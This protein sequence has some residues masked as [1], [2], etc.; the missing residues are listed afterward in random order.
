MLAC[1]VL[2][3]SSTG[4]VGDP[5]VVFDPAALGYELR[6]TVE[7][8]QGLVNRTG[9]R[10][11]LG[12]PDDPWL[13]IYAERN[14]I[15][16]ETETDLAALFRRFGGEARG[17]VVYDP[18]VDGG[19]YVAATIAGAEGLLPV[20]P[21]FLSEASPIG[22]LGLPTVRDLR[23]QFADSVA[24]YD[25][26]IA[27]VFPECN[28]HLGLAVDATCEGI[29]TGLCGPLAG[30]DWSVQNR[31][32][33]FNLGVCPEPMPSYGDTKVGGSPEQAACYRRILA[34]LEAPAQINGYGEPEDYWCKLISEYG[35]YSFHYGYNWSFHS[36][37]PETRPLKQRVSY[38]PENVTPE[39]DR[40]A[41]CFMTSEGDTMKG[42]L[43]FFM[44]SWFDTER[45][46]VPVNWGINPLMADLFPAMLSYYYD[47]ATEQ[48]CFF[49]GCSGAGYAY[50]DYMPNLEQFASVTGEMCRKADIS[51]VDLWM[52]AKD[53]VRRRYAEASG[54]MGLSA[55]VGRARFTMP[56]PGVP[57]IDHGLMYWQT[58]ATA[59]ETWFKAFADDTKRAK[60]IDWLVGR[61]EDIARHHEAPFVI[62]VYGDLHSYAHHATC[63]REVADQLDPARFRPM[64]LDE[65]MAGLAAWSKGR[66]LVDAGGINER[67]QWAALEGVPT[68]VPLG[69]VSNASEPAD[70]RITARVGQ[71]QTRTAV[72]V[73]PGARTSADGLMLLLA[74]GPTTREADLTIEGPWGE[75]VRHPTVTLVPANGV[76]AR[77]ASLVGVWDAVSLNHSGGMERPEPDALYGR[78]WASPDGEGSP[79]SHII[80][81]PY[82]DA[83]AGRC[84]AAFRLKLLAPM[85]DPEAVVA[86]LDVNPG[87]YEGT[88]KPLGTRP[89][90]ARKFAA[91]GEWQWFAI[92]VDWPG[93]PN[94]M[95]TRVYWAAKAG[96]AVDRVAAFALE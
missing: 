55:N 66:V 59:P 60:A 39:T 54:A 26:A 69:L 83:P 23:G 32:V 17:L 71:F 34:A 5:A 56:I 52:A 77:S 57:M 22:A 35:H 89:L 61:I 70:A 86:T 37:V 14:G 31:G 30:L 36:K 75:D 33:V 7:A 41:V 45:G 4:A 40:Y 79:Q 2:A 11:F 50:P 48:D 19:R 82:V 90:R 3:A 43:P 49:A 78:A 64:R 12:T 80:C 87:G 92:E 42:P 46:K 96:L 94:R 63:Y 51:C 84:L 65:A 73:A 24:A 27:E 67:I 38:T 44:G 85:N 28:R 72:N 9:P 53:D 68:G 16:Y 47:T 29:V 21:E 88:G 58:T 93:A 10:L 81:G 15:V 25:W 8:L 74:G 95:E 76:A 91:V 1:L 6:C 13:D 20:A 62:L 18:E